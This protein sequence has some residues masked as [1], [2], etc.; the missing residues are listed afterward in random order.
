MRVA[1]YTALN[2]RPLIKKIS[3]RRLKGVYAQI[4]AVSLLCQWLN[5]KQVV[6]AHDRLVSRELVLDGAVDLAELGHVGHWHRVF[7]S[8]P[9]RGRITTKAKVPGG[10]FSTATWTEPCPGLAL[11]AS[12]TPSTEHG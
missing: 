2:S 11:T 6:D 9:F 4:R 1:S 10:D 5:H 3:S 12:I 7:Q 8:P